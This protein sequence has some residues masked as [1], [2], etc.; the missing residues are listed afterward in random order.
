MTPPSLF[1]RRSSAPVSYR[2]SIEFFSVVLNQL[3]E[4]P[5]PSCS[6]LI[7]APFCHLIR[8]PTF[9][10]DK[11][12]A[13]SIGIPP[14]SWAHFIV[15]N[16][17]SINIVESSL[18]VLL[19]VTLSK[20]AHISDFEYGKTSSKNPGITSPAIGTIAS[21]SLGSSKAI[22]KRPPEKKVLPPRSFLLAF[23]RTKTFFAPVS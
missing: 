19:W 11:V 8:L 2:I 1:L 15:S 17:L 14:Y 7:I 12:E 5:I 10:P 4:R 9:I 20:S 3:V 16:E 23:S 13:G 21:S 6:A 22:L 18:S